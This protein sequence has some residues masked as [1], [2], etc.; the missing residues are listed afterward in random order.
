MITVCRWCGGPRTIVSA[1]LLRTTAW[2]A[3]LLCIRC[4]TDAYGGGKGPPK[5]IKIIEERKSDMQEGEGR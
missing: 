5:L 4:D 3:W 1:K 2:V